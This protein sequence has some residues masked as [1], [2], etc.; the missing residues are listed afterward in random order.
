MSRRNLVEQFKET[1]YRRRIT[2]QRQLRVL[3]MLSDC[4]E[5]LPE[6]EHFTA[7]IVTGYDKEEVKL[8]LNSDDAD[9]LGRVLQRIKHYKLWE[10][11]S[12]ER[13][14]RSPSYSEAEQVKATL[15][16]EL[17][18][19]S[20]GKKMPQWPEKIH[21]QVDSDAVPPAC[22]VVVRKAKQIYDTYEKV[23][24]CTDPLT[25]EV[26]ETIVLARA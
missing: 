18:L 8:Y 10:M 16:I 21:L 1:M 20:T 15:V 6:A 5:E 9:L 2:T 14:F 11:V 24:R 3:G 25:G 23:V 17:S 7:Y 4:F 26:Q 19:E 22:E 12:W 13:K